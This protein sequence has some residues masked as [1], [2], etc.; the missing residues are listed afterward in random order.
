MSHAGSPYV[1]AEGEVDGAGF[2]DARTPGERSD[3]I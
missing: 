3:G 2:E 1:V